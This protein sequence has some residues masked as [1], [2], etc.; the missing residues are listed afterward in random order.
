V[1]LLFAFVPVL[2]GGVGFVAKPA[3]TLAALII[4]PVLKCS[5]LIANIPYG[6]IT[7][8]NS[9]VAVTVAITALVPILL[10]FVGRSVKRFAALS[11]GVVCLWMTLANAVRIINT[12]PVATILPNGSTSAYVIGYGNKAII[13]DMGCKGSLNRGI[14]RLLCDRGLNTTE[15]MFISKEAEYTSIRA[16]NDFSS[17]PEIYF[18]FNEISADNDC[19]IYVNSTVNI[20]GMNI[21]ATDNG[22]TV[23]Y[24]GF[25]L[26]LSPNAFTVNEDVYD[27]TKEEYP[28]EITLGKSQVRRLDYGFD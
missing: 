8:S 13:F 11:C 7:A 26:E 19:R 17:P 9:A 27:I 12:D 15:C 10:F 21:T 22:Y 28:M 2:L 5:A 14:E 16:N 20:S 18:T 25:C 1:A 3:F 24:D 6:Y 23:E 4:K